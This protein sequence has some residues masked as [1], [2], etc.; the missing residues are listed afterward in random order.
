MHS[1]WVDLSCRVTGASLHAVS[2]QLR[3]K[4]VRRGYQWQLSS[5]GLKLSYFLARLRASFVI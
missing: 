4:Q 3:P 2:P 1:H 5:N